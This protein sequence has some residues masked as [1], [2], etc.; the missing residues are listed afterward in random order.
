MQIIQVMGFSSVCAVEEHDY[1]GF[2]GVD[3]RAV[4]IYHGIW[5]MEKEEGRGS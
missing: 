2:E 5:T 3:G 4:Q 1:M